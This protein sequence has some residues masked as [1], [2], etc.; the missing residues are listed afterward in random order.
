MALTGRFYSRGQ[1]P[2][3]TQLLSKAVLLTID[4]TLGSSARYAFR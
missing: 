3:L 4:L 1:N 2:Y